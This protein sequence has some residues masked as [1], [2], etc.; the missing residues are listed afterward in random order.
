VSALRIDQGIRPLPRSELSQ[1]IGDFLVDRQ[2]RGLSPGTIQF[3]QE[4]LRI[5]KAF[6]EARGTH[7]VASVTPADLRQF[8]LHLGD[9]RNP[10]GMHVAYRA[11]RTFLRWYWL[12]YD[13]QSPNPITK[14]RPPKVVQQP[15]EPLPLIDI[16]A[17]LKTCERRTFTGDRDR[18]LLLCL[19]A[20]C[21]R[22]SWD[23]LSTGQ[24][25]GSS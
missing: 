24:A 18:A 7:S 25:E 15:L 17:M 9:R 5:L 14:V 2:A 11:L 23:S 12:E 1:D 8:L 20:A 3:Y 22:G 6:L 10:G 16:Q 4:E 13:I 21:R 19:L